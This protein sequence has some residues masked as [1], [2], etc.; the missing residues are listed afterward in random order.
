MGL[1]RLPWTVPVAA[2]SVLLHGR[3]IGTVGMVAAR[4]T[5][6]DSA[7]DRYTRVAV[8]AQRVA[9]GPEARAG[10]LDYGLTLGLRI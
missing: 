5:H 10:P 3:A 7:I 1:R 8:A 9:L 2:A 6:A 4:V